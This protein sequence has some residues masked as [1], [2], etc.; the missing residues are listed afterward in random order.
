[1]STRNFT[2]LQSIYAAL[3][4]GEAIRLVGDNSGYYMKMEDG[5]LKEFK[6]ENRKL[7]TGCAFFNPSHYELVDIVEPSLTENSER[8]SRAIKLIDHHMSVT[9]GNNQGSLVSARKLLSEVQL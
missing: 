2:N 9:G 8:V 7:I 6:D 3:L 5:F 4:N 1:M